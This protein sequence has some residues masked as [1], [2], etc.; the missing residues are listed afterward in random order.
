[1]L[2]I[3]KFI[4]IQTIIHV[5]YTAIQKPIT[6]KKFLFL[7]ERKLFYLLI[8]LCYFIYS[9]IVTLFCMLNN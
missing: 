2:R 7:K 1:M 8:V 5:K 6:Q 3:I 4:N 9:F